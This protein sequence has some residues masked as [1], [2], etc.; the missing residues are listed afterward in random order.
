[1]SH[2]RNTPGCRRTYYGRISGASLRSRLLL[3]LLCISSSGCHYRISTNFFVIQAI[4]TGKCEFS[5]FC[6][7]LGA[8]GKS[9]ATVLSLLLLIVGH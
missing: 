8:R 5:C 4:R 3:F 1:M 7:C 6:L 2:W 9:N